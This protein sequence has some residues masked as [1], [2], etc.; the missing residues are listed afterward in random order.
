VQA[1]RQ[2]NLLGLLN[3]SEDTPS[4]WDEFRSHP[5]R[6]D[7]AALNSTPSDAPSTAATSSVATSSVARHR[8]RRWVP[9]STTPVRPP[10]Q[11]R[12]TQ[13]A[14]VQAVSHAM[15]ND[16]DFRSTRAAD[17][18]R[19]VL[20][21]SSRLGQ[22]WDDAAMEQAARITSRHARQLRYVSQPSPGSD[23]ILQDL[24]DQ[25]IELDHVKTNRFERIY[26]RNLERQRA[27]MPSW[28]M[29]DMQSAAG[30]I[31]TSRANI[32]VARVDP[33]PEI[34]AIQSAVG[35]AMQAR[36]A[37][38]RYVA[39]LNHNETAG[40]GW[41]NRDMVRAAGIDE[42]GARRIRNQR[43]QQQP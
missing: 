35:A 13:S 10:Q 16:P 11:G 5:E 15:A 2:S 22:P 23:A 29:R 32:V 36:F 25:G 30:G 38:E 34:R 28:D 20:Q 7:W 43:S 31:T 19:A 3:A 9:Y 6:L 12:S 33:S 14:D 40:M 37:Q 27:H 21:A 41:T 26:L 17:R 39:I 24:E 42:S 1:V 18:Y 4:P 8:R